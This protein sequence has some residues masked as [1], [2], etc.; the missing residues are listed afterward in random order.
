VACPDDNTLVAMIEHA[1]DP[2]RLAEIEV[3]VDTCE[4]CRRVVAESGGSSLLA[5]GSVGSAPTEAEEQAPVRSSQ[6]VF[7]GRYEIERVLGQGGMGKVYLA[8]DKTLG[9]EV[10]LKLHRASSGVE[11]RSAIRE[12]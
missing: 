12:R 10:A 1:L 4:K 11:R 8:R 2:K 6:P 7:E 3:H 5:L 9:R